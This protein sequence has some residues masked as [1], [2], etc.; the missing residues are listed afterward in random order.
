MV[1]REGLPVA[2]LTDPDLRVPADS[3]A[4]L[5]E[6]TAVRSGVDDFGLRLAETRRLSNL[7]PLGLVVR[8]QPTLRA[9]I[10][11]AIRYLW[12]QNEGMTYRI[13]QAGSRVVLRL[14]ILIDRP[15]G[16]QAIELIIGVLVR[17][18]R[19]LVGE[20]WRPIAVAF[21]HAAPSSL[22]SHRRVL[23]VTPT[24]GQDFT[25]LTLF[26]SDLDVPIAGADPE[27]ARQLERYIE[28]TTSQ[29]RADFSGTARVLVTALLATGSCSAE[30]LAAQMGVSRRT[31]HRRL[32][33]Q[34]LTFMRVLD[35][36]LATGASSATA[37]R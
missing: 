23:G 12:M 10:E 28:W 11:W 19:A 27:M 22:A 36:V 6:A 16:R 20:Q 14:L 25:G 24:F 8:E 9:A 33:R 35:D 32:A 5:L 4:S 37:I 2:C 3:I 26:A 13:E 31:M 17:T 7:G 29:R 18:L 34:D 30:R 15:P 21:Q 1:A